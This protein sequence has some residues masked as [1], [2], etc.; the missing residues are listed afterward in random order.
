MQPEPIPARLVA[1]PDFCFHGQAK[2]P[3]GLVDFFAQNPQLSS[4]NGTDSS[5]LAQSRA[6]TKLP[7]RPSQLES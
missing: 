1:T 6:E 2:A 5:V 3:L 7:L 4:V